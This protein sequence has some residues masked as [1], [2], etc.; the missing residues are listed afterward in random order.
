MDGAHVA[1]AV[2][3]VLGIAIPVVGFWRM[4]KLLDKDQAIDAATF[5]A[6]RDLRDWLERNERAS[7]GRP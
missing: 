3:M 4:S 1:L 7:G 6:L 2:L 5:L